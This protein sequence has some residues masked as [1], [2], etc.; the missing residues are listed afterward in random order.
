MGIRRLS[1]RVPGIKTNLENGGAI[2]NAPCNRGALIS[3][4]PVAL[5]RVTIISRMLGGPH[6]T[7]TS[8][9]HAV[10]GTEA[11]ADEAA[12]SGQVGASQDGVGTSDD[13]DGSHGLW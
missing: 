8:N 11:K 10:N 2:E 7:R 4:P 1:A 5:N 6:W 13:L 3:K 9:L 12:R